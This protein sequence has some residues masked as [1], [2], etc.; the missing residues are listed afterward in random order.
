MSD[1]DLPPPDVIEVSV[2]GRGSGESVL[3]HYG[4]GQWI[5]VDSF[6][7]DGEPIAL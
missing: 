7:I 5:I 1:W 6:L 4:D 3:V 2:F